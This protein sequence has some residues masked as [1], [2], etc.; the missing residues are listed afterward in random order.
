M[1]ALTL[2]ACGEAR[3]DCRHEKIHRGDGTVMGSCPCVAS[4]AA[5]SS[6]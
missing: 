6:H 4:M 2:Q 1:Y 5:N 3:G